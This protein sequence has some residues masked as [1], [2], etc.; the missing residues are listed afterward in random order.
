MARQGWGR[1][2]AAGTLLATAIAGASG[3]PGQGQGDRAARA[4]GQT[5]YV[6]R[7]ISDAITMDPGHFYEFTA[8]MVAT[9]CYDTLITFRPGDAAH[10]VPDLADLPTVGDGG[11]TYAFALHPGIRFASGDPLT[12]ED[13]VFSYRRL[14]ALGDNP[15]F[16]AAGIAR[17]EAI[18]TL[19]VRITLAGPDVSFLAA[20]ATTNFSVLDS[21][22]LR[23]HGGNDSP[24]AS[25]LDRARTFLDGRSAGTGA[26]ALA[27]W[28]AGREIV[29]ERNP[30][31]R[32]TAPYYGRIIFQGIV[33]AP[34]QRLAV[35]KG[36][37]DV[38]MGIDLD[39]A[40]SLGPGSGVT[41][42]RGDTLDLIYIGMNTAA[43]AG[44][45]LADPRVRLAVR[46]A[47]DY[48]GILGGLLRGVGT[49]PNSMI[50]VGMLGNDARF[51]ASVLMGQDTGRARAL[52]AASGHGRGLALS[53]DYDLH[54]TFDGVG[55]D[56]LA[57]KIR[58][59]LGRVGI[60]LSLRPRV[61]TGLL[62][63]YRAGKTQ[64]VLYNWGVD[65][66]DPNDYAGPFSPGGGPAG[67]LSYRAGP[68]LARAVATA[69]Q[70]TDPGTRAGLYHQIQRDWLREGPWIALVQPQNLTVL[71]TGIT[72]Y[73][74]NAVLP[75]DFRGIRGP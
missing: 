58:T 30:A 27:S 12:A 29:L 15:S 28:T 26:Y 73:T 20:L 35:Q 25:R 18:G 49:R 32:G 10:P 71:G 2:L 57:T 43:R 22:L 47:L 13:V 3:G 38:A 65:Y 66:P 53:M 4:A 56:R 54:A 75:G 37:A 36:Q 33:D 63:D 16:L 68:D 45:A 31:Y 34:T 23:A 74:Y 55:F 52:L 6:A 61:D 67:R 14:R 44:G 1:A 60:H 42:V 40:A 50:P 64:M 69:D 39:Q 9:N 70:A 24:G 19:G 51:N 41:I 21:R 46:L 59:D 72:G 17:I 8:N 5:L 11:R 7:D 48:N 62:K